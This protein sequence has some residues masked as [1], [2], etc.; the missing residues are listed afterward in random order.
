M[1]ERSEIDAK[2]EEFDINLSDVQRDYMFSWVLDG[3]YGHSDLRDQLVLKG[4]NC[5]R[6]AYFKDTRF[7]R[8][9]DFAAKTKLDEEQVG[10]SLL[11]VQSF[12]EDQTGV[13]F[14]RDD[15]WVGKKKRIGP[16][17]DVMEARLYFRDFYG[18]QGKMIIGIRLDI[19]QDDR[20]I[21]PVQRRQIIHPYSDREQLTSP[22]QCLKV[23]ELLAA[24][25]KCL[26]QRRYSPDF[27]D[28][29][30]WLLF[31]D[32]LE[33]NK[34]E[35]ARAFFQMT[36][37]QRSPEAARDLLINLPFAAIRGLWDKF[38][39][40]PKN[41]RIIFD[42][43]IESFKASLYELF[44][45]APAGRGAK[46]FF[47]AELRNPIMEAANNFTLLDLKYDGVVRQVEPYAL[48]YKC[49]KDGVEREYFY[50]YDLTGGRS[51]E[52]GIKTFV[53]DK[54]L[55]IKN[56]DTQF[57]PRFE[58]E[59]KKAGELPK[60][61][62]FG[63]PFSGRRVGSRGTRLVRKPRRSRV[64]RSTSIYGVTYTIKCPVCGKRFNRKNYDTK[65]NKHKDHYGNYCYAKTGLIVG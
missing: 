21:L 63:R 34:L 15:Y 20:I 31:N 49:R 59:L 37:F 9:L 27:F 23:E 29:A 48:S 13:V 24:K 55:S 28:C 12:I 57:E 65:L 19:T 41:C 45:D 60:R 11:Q 2:A 38:I 50:A 32:Q 43:A 10:R 42:E 51:S 58:V 39:V 16:N 35:I 1:I 7:S 4:G 14:N 26:L 64:S 5:F 18:R 62:Y 8:D 40:C 47:P 22:I 17:V 53:A 6:K 54:V 33:I 56:T 25:L 52:P 3:I 44:G 46:A 61:T 36:I 30:A